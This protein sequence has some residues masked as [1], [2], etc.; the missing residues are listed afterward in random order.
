MGSG[1]AP[2]SILG[3]EA[4]LGSETIAN[5]RELQFLAMPRLAAIAEGAGAPA[6]RRD[7]DRFRVRLGQQGPRWSAI[8]INFYRAPDV[9]WK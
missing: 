2:E 3:V 7:W 8:G 4:P 1:A 9:P 5:I 6:D